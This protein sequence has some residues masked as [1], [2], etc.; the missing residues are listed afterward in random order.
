MFTRF[1]RSNRSDASI[2]IFRSGRT[3]LWPSYPELSMLEE[4]RLTLHQLQQQHQTCMSTSFPKANPESPVE[5]ICKIEE[6]VDSL[7]QTKS[8][9]I[10]ITDFFL[11]TSGVFPFFD[12]HLRTVVY[13]KD[14]VVHDAIMQQDMNPRIL[15]FAQNSSV[16][17]TNKKIR[18]HYKDCITI[19]IPNS[20]IEKSN[21]I[22]DLVRVYMRERNM[23]NIGHWGNF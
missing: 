6:F 8:I 17:N 11:K 19:S 7:N 14:K 2:R 10:C 23:L 18:V 9:T 4:S 16:R 3:T 13:T 21:L 12:K 22:D 15:L 1:L 5:N 20:D